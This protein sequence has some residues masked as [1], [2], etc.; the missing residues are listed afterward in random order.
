MAI[1]RIRVPGKI[2][3]SGEHAVVYGFPALVMAVDRQLTVA[4][5]YGPKAIDPE[6]FHKLLADFPQHSVLDILNHLNA[7]DSGLKMSVESNIPIG[8]GM[9][10]SAAL[11]AGVAAIVLHLAGRIDRA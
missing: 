4:V 2:I 5:E 1:L 11:A 3:L 10:S 6:Y 9:G 7:A 8:C